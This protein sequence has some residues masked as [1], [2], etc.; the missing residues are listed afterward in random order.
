MTGPACAGDC[1]L[2]IARELGG[3]P[4]CTGCWSKVSQNARTLLK[5]AAKEVGIRP[6]NTKVRERYDAALA[7]AARY[8]A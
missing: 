1:G 2:P 3:I 4:F 5:S 8:C 7:G 6:L